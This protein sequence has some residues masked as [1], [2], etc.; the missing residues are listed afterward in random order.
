MKKSSILLSILLGLALVQGCKKKEEKAADPAPMA[1]TGTATTTTPPPD[2]NAGTAAG[3]GAMAGT[4][5]GTG[6]DMAGT[7]AGTG[8]AAAIEDVKKLPD[9]MP[10]DCTKAY[11]AMVKYKGCEKHPA[12][13]RAQ[14][15]KAWNAAVDGTFVHYKDAKGDTK[16][17]IA[18]TCTSMVQTS[19][20]LVKDC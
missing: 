8:A 7:G 11:D 12:D 5:A 2:P 9:G 16:A 20:M 4:G 6:G 17:T 3:T 13:S 18:K 1:G 14:M 15:I 10:A 19:E